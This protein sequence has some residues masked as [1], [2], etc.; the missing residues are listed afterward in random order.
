MSSCQKL[1][2]QEKEKQL[3]EAAATAAE[4]EAEAGGIS[5]FIKISFVT[6]LQQS[7]TVT[8]ADSEEQK[9]NLGTDQEHDL[10]QRIWQR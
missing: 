5:K 7:E 2:E 6:L 8:A 4:S 1:E 10:S 3:I 9:T